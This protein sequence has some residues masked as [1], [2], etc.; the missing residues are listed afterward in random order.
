[1]S[2]RFFDDSTACSS[3]GMRA[4]F[5]GF[6]T[7]EDFS[8]VADL[9]AVA[10]WITVGARRLFHRQPAGG[11]GR[12]FEQHVG[13]QRIL[14]ADHLPGFLFRQQEIDRQSARLVLSAQGMF[15][16]ADP[17]VTG[18]RSRLAASAAAAR[19]SPSA[20]SPT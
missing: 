18:R 5:G 12:A 9:S 13:D 6:S 20:S 15:H 1:M 2:I 19:H 11:A 7:V 4:S 10:G 3:S 17:S 8:I 16:V 14:G